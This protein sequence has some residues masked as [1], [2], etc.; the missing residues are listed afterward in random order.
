MRAGVRGANLPA[1][2][3]PPREMAV[4]EDI[5][6]CLEEQRV[7]KEAS[8]HPRSRWQRLDP[9]A[10]FNLHACEFHLLSLISLGSFCPR[11]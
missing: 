5:T 7:W 11:I 1:E 2:G 10:A 6:R 8:C 3:L 9:R 4:K